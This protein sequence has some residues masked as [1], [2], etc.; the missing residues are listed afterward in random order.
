MSNKLYSQTAFA[1]HCIV[2]HFHKPASSLAMIILILLPPSLKVASASQ[3]P[4]CFCHSC[5]CL[6]AQPAPLSTVASATQTPRCFCHS[7]FCLPDPRLL[8]PQLPL[9]PS[10]VR[11]TVHSCLCHSDPRLL[12]PQLPLPPSLVRATVHSC[13]CHRCFCFR[14]RHNCFCLPVLVCEVVVMRCCHLMNRDELI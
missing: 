4:R 13:L 5:F 7:C 10:P 14:R 6:P 1:T 11:A 8:L 3:T 2:H 9:P 12:L